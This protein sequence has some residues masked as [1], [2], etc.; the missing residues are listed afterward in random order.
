VIVIFPIDLPGF[1]EQAQRSSPAFMWEHPQPVV[2]DEVKYAP[3]LFRQ[4]K[5]EIDKDRHAMGRFIFTGRQHFVLM[6]GVSESLAGTA[7]VN[8]LENLS[9]EE[10]G[11]VHCVL[12]SLY[13]FPQARMHPLPSKAVG[14]KGQAVLS[15]LLERY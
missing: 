3:G 15:Y 8:E 5:A 7:A 4:V 11:A 9:R 13:D 14:G 6:K 1:A 10:I 2:I 12:G